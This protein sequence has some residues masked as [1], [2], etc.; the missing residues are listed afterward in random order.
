MS[1]TDPSPR[2]D[3]RSLLA[4]L[5]ALGGT[6]LLSRCGPASTTN[7]AGADTASG[8]EASAATDSA[9]AEAGTCHTIASETTGPYPDTMGM[10][11]NAA[12]GRSNIKE[13]RAGTALRLVL[14]ILDAATCAPLVGARVM[15][16][17][18]D[19]EGVYS[20]YA[21]SMNA[22]STS[23]TY[24]RG[25]Q[26]T[27]ANGQVTFETI[28]PG[29]YL[30]RATHVH[31]EVFNP[32]SL[33]APKKVTQLGFPEEVNRAVYAQSAPYTRGQ[34]QSSNDTDQVFGG[35]VTATGDGD[36]G[37]HAYQLAAVTGNVT[38]GY[39]ATLQVALTG[40]A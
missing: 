40:Y 39:V 8:A 37:G 35:T 38:S 15:V 16:W 18:C 26:D 2:F 6:A 23:T 34:N 32:A 14:T 9:A 28:F 12:F 3:R 13:D 7:D 17:H 4:A 5:G 29:W 24:L 11:S 20:E 30:P 19:K 1:N 27:D 21:N 36:G 10:L 25:W 22:G 31:V 33:S